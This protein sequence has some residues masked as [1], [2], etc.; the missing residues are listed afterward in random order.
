V[1]SALAKKVRLGALSPEQLALVAAAYRASVDSSFSVIEPKR[2]HFFSATRLLDRP[3]I[4]LRSADAPHLAIAA[5]NGLTVATLDAGMARAGATLGIA[6][7]S[8]LT[9]P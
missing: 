5:A 4:G 3:E 7:R 1:A 6:T 8:P 9:I 2:S